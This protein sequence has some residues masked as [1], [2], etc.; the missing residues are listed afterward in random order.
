MRA[1]I[2]ERVA[3]TISGH[4]TLSVFDRYNIVSETDISL[5]QVQLNMH[6][7]KRANGSTASRNMDHRTDFDQTTS[8]DSSSS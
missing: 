1:G 3:M 4:K 7:D 6:V 8:Q 2:S 5:A